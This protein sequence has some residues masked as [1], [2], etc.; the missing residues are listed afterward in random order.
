VVSL[1]LVG[2]IHAEHAVALLPERAA[3]VHDVQGEAEA[4]GS[5]AVELAEADEHGGPPV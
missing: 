3:G 1:G 2:E 4:V 5:D